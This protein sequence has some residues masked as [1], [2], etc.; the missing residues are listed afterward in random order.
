MAKGAPLLL[1]QEQE[2]SLRSIVGV[3]AQH[4]EGGGLSGAVPTVGA[5]DHDAAPVLQDL[6]DDLEAGTQDRTQVVV[7]TRVCHILEPS[8]RLA[9]GDVGHRGTHGTPRIANA[10]DVVD[11]AEDKPALGVTLEAATPGLVRPSA[12]PRPQVDD[13]QVPVGLAP[14]P[15]LTDALDQGGILVALLAHEPL[16]GLRAA[17][18]R[19]VLQ[20]RTAAP[21]HRRQAAPLPETGDRPELLVRHVARKRQDRGVRR[22]QPVVRVQLG[23]APG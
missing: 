15:A 5:V 14:L 22:T 19:R 13:E 3:Q 16:R 7:P 2:A 12:L 17:P 18:Q 8:A 6:L 21:A 10:M 23:H 9:L 20:L 11:A 4:R 1:D